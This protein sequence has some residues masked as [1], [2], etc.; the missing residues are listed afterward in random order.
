[1]VDNVEVPV[2][3]FDHLVDSE[4]LDRIDV[5]KIDVEGSEE[6]V[7]EGAK[8]SLR[9]FRPLILLELQDPS[10]RTLGSSV[11]QVVSLLES[12]DYRVVGYSTASGRLCPH[13]IAWHDEQDHADNPNVVAVPREWKGGILT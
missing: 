9:R 3:T 11:P 12:L 1:M 10:L 13:D 2:T 8:L 7:L 5:V 6:L 4:R